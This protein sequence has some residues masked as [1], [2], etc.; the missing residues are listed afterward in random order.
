MPPEDDLYIE[1]PKTMDAVVRSLGGVVSDDSNEPNKPRNADYW[2][3]DACVIA[4]LK[5]WTE[6][7]AAKASF[8]E[9]IQRLHRSWVARGLVRP[10][11]AGVNRIS[12]S[13]LPPACAEEFT[14][15]IKKKVE[16]LVRE[17]AAQIKETRQRLDP[18]AKGLLLLANDGNP[19]MKMDAVAHVLHRILKRQHSA[20][21][22]LIYFSANERVQVPGFPI[23]TAFW[24][25]MGIEGR[26]GISK[27]FLDR[28]SD[29]WF[30]KVSGQ[31]GGQSLPVFTVKSDPDLVKK[32][33]FE[34]KPA[35][36]RPS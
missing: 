36:P 24:C 5:C 22:S 32:V 17:A 26:E 29:G 1:I 20:I 7:L 6:D 28:L 33:V 21:H 27:A 35:W 9:Q 14:S 12:T 3:P 25:P 18:S 30:R 19:L 13:D 16:G 11:S 2:F 15:L 23:P 8:Q 34:R 4:E 10:L 31:L